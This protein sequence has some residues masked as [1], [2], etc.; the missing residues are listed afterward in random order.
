MPKLLNR[1]KLLLNADVIMNTKELIKA[2]ALKQR[3]ICSVLAAS[4]LI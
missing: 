4:L 2:L 3:G 1:N